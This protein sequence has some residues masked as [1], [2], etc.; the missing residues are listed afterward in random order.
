MP[1]PICRGFLLA[2]FVFAVG[3]TAATPSH[4]N[5]L[6]IA[7]DD[8]RPALGCYGDPQVKTPHIDRLAAQSLLL[9]RAY[10]QVPVCGASRASLM[11][12]VLPR[13]NRFTTHLSRADEDAPGVATLPQVFKEAGYTTLSNGKVFHNSAD[14]KERS[15]SAGTWASGLGHSASLDPTTA[16]AKSAAGR[17]RIYEAPDVPDDAYGD[18]KLA[19][20]TI[21]DLGRLKAAGKPFFLACGFIRPHL[22]FY[23]PKKYWDLYDRDKIVL[24]ED[25]RRPAAAPAGLKGSAEYRTYAHGG[26]TDGTDAFHRMMRHGYYASTSYVDKLVGDVLAELTRL[27]L[28]DNTIVVLWGDHGWNLGEHDFWGKHNTLDTAV[29]VPLIVKVPGRTSGQKSDALVG[30][31]DLFPTLC[32]LANLP[33][34]ATVQGRSFAGLVAD[35]K[36]KFRD[37]V[38]TRFGQGDA[39]VTQHL[40]YTRYGEDGEM[41]YDLRTDPAENQ[42]LAGKPSHQKDVVAMRELLAASQKTAAAANVPPPLSPPA[43]SKSA[44]QKTL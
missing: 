1:R 12:G 26:Y 41:L 5:V 38:Y 17:S 34:P 16:G 3:A 44:K 24:A 19:G 14:T 39:I 32:A 22:P 6:F 13:P 15:W 18:G 11:T 20:K 30:A 21:A 25:R 40:I 36:Q 28:A 31:Y 8:L 43:K 33:I 35:P 29:R 23:A 10:C 37:S 9:N 27:G 4:S 2:L 42:N 7:I